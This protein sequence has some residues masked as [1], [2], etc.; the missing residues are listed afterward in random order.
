MNTQ[1][2]LTPSFNPKRTITFTGRL[3]KYYKS[4]LKEAILN[5]EQ[6]YIIWLNIKLERASKTYTKQMA[7]LSNSII[8]KK[9]EK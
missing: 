1:L 3:V 5:N 8:R 4:E 6:D 2:T 9:Y 7:K